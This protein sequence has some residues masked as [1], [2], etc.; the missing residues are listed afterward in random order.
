VL[1]VFAWIIAGVGALVLII[2]LCAGIGGG[3]ASS[4]SLGGSAVAVSGAGA[5][6]FAVVEAVF[7]GLSALFTFGMSELIIL[8]ISMEESTRAT[9]ARIG[10]TS[11]AYPPYAPVGSAYAPPPS[12]PTTGPGYPSSPPMYPPGQ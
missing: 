2:T 8:F 12:L 7:F 6:V 5:L 10:G 4:N 9:A 1:K 11:A 3:L